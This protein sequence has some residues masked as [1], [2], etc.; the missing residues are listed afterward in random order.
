MFDLRRKPSL[1]TTRLRYA[2]PLMESRR[3][4]ATSILPP[5][6]LKDDSTMSIPFSGSLKLEKILKMRLCQCGSKADLVFLPS[7]LHWARTD[8][9]ASTRTPKV[10]PSTHGL[11]TTTSI[12]YTL[13]NLFKLA[14]H[15]T[16]LST[17]RSMSLSR[18]L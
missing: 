10:P 15:T 2:R 13:I 17:A 12:C 14:F 16:R 4:A 8:P 5:I 1:T 18:P 9:A 3:T 11:G 6:Q 7:M